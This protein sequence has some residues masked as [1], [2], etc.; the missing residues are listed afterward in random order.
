MFTYN[1]NNLTSYQKNEYDNKNRIEKYYIYNFNGQLTIFAQNS[2]WNN[3]G[4]QTT[5]IHYNNNGNLYAILTN[6]IY[7]EQG[8]F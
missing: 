2:T 6:Y 4:N 3:N 8:R 7:D 5:Q 1:Q